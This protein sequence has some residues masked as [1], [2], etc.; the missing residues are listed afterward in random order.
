F[1]DS[2]AAGSTVLIQGWSG[3][4]VVAQGENDQVR[5]VLPREGV[6][7]FVDNIAILKSSAKSD[8]AHQFINFLLRPEIAAR[9]SNAV[10]YATPNQNALPEVDEALRN[11]PAYQ[12]P[13]PEKTH[14]LLDVGDDVLEVYERVWS[15]V[16]GL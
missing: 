15:E 2:L 1:E 9:I 11:G 14:L 12:L 5:Y 4:T 6:L 16:K 3:E 7:M 8:A 13:P 10:Q